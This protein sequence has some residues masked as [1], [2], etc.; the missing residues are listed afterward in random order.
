MA[1][2]P[3]PEPVV[4]DFD[5]VTGYAERT[6]PAEP[7]TATVEAPPAAPVPVGAS[8]AVLTSP[9]DLLNAPLPGS[10]IPPAREWHDTATGKPVEPPEPKPSLEATPEPVATVM[11]DDVMPQTT[12][13]GEPDGALLWSPCAMDCRGLAE[14]GCDREPACLSTNPDQ[15]LAEN[16]KRAYDLADA[17]EPLADADDLLAALADCIPPAAAPVYAPLAEVYTPELAPLEPLTLEAVADKF[18]DPGQLLE[19][20]GPDFN[21]LPAAEQQR[22]LRYADA[23]LPDDPDEFELPPDMVPDR[24]HVPIGPSAELADL[25]TSVTVEL[26]DGTVVDHTAGMTIEHTDS[27][28]PDVATP[29]PAERIANGQDKTLPHS[30]SKPS[31]RSPEQRHKADVVRSCWM[32]WCKAALHIDVAPACPIQF[33]AAV[34]IFDAVVADAELTIE[35]WP[36]EPP[37]MPYKGDAPT[38][39]SATVAPQSIGDYVASH[40]EVDTS[41]TV[42][43][44]RLIA[45]GAMPPVPAPLPPQPDDVIVTASRVVQAPAPKCEH[46]FEKRSQCMDCLSELGPDL[47]E[48]RPSADIT[49]T[50]RP[51]R[52]MMARVESPCPR[53]GCP[54]AIEPGDMIGLTEYGWCC[55]HCVGT[56]VPLAVAGE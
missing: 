13:T 32:E 20:L 41:T 48:R 52:T 22:L 12:P 3:T 7:P 46:G 24:G 23:Q 26:P 2:T 21:A 43:P 34:R 37:V 27:D 38:Q 28:E 31:D 4:V 9:A 14:F 45:E 8:P 49:Q 39:D 53:P 40:P 15:R 16:T 30:A 19:L 42:P 1:A 44:H 25:V 51:S 33:D 35:T 18:A 54:R 11:P 29:T 50:L 36:G 10:A 55:P 56:E 6:R 17:A 47:A 5:E